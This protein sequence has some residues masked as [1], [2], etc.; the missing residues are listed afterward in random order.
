MDKKIK[1]SFVKGNSEFEVPKMTVRR[2]EEL[3]DT[4]KELKI[5][6]TKEQVRF[7]REFNKYMILKSLQAVDPKV[8]LEDINNMHPDD[9]LYVFNCIWNSGRE[10]R[11]DKNF[12]E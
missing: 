4:V 5:D 1:L 12:Q 9:F 3:M 6:E 10:I 2:Q 7:N 8:T 11:S